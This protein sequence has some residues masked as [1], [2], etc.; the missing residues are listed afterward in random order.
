MSPAVR[1]DPS[2]TFRR[3]R[4]TAI[5]VAFC[6]LALIAFA[7]GA[8]AA[9]DPGLKASAKPGE[10]AILAAAK[11]RNP[12][13][14]RFTVRQGAKVALTSDRRSFTVSWRPKAGVV[15]RGAIVSLH[16]FSSSAFDQFA[17]WQSYAKSHGLGLIAVQWRRGFDSQA[18]TYHPPAILS[19][20]ADALKR[21]KIPRGAA[22]LHGFSSGGIRVYALAALDNRAAKR[23]GLFLANS[24][25]AVGNYPL[26]RQIEGGHFGAKP[27]AGERF[28]LFCGRKDPHPAY[29]GCPAMDHTRKVV[30]TRGGEVDDVIADP[31]G[32][33]AS[34]FVHPANVRRALRDFDR[35]LTERGF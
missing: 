7:A 22:L 32:G 13:R 17:F 16:G 2:P 10:P 28:V 3:R 5:A 8:M 25:A 31:T 1:V 29:T 19:F 21:M 6:A 35:V 30:T 26:G 4:R 24:G 18:F 27:F 12:Q 9:S 23:F 20:A 34:F 11:V 14:Y 33:H 15:P